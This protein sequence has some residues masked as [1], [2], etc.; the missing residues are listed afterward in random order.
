MFPGCKAYRLYERGGA[1]IC[2]DELGVALG[3]LTLVER[4]DGAALRYRTCAPGVFAKA[5]VMA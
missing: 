5:F 2:C 3:S 1:G 4:V